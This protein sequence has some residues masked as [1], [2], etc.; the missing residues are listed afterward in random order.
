MI[1]KTV[2]YVDFEGVERE[3]NFFFN[4][5]EAELTELELSET[6]GLKKTLER[7]IEAQNTKELVRIFK[8][9]LLQAYGEKSLDGR[10]F[11]KSEEITKNFEQ[12]VAYSDIF[13]ELAFDDE[14]ASEFING[15]IVAVPKRQPD[16]IYQPK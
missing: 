12:T 10:R 5:T 13:M 4:L 1:K 9:L 16:P 14:K 11:V 7:I 3:E 15:L 8:V 6:G 2:K